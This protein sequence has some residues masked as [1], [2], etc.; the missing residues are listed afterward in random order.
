MIELELRRN[1]LLTDRTLGRLWTKLGSTAV[2]D[3]RW[4][5][6]EDTLRE[7]WDG[8]QWAWKP[9]FK[10]PEQTCIPHG[11][12]QV[13]M[14]QSKR[15]ARMLPHILNVPDFSA[16]EIHTGNTPT[17]THGCVLV[18]KSIVNND[19]FLSKAALGELFEE[20]GDA[21]TRGILW[22]TVT[23]PPGGTT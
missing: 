15:F 10:I 13:K 20:F 16:I 8:T 3:S 23:N 22:L 1:D 2:E 21:I 7:Q 14:L 19:L 6:L 4:A 17:D 12:Y 18:G 5:T 11:H 9:E